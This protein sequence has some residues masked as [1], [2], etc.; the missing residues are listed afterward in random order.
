MSSIELPAHKGGLF[1]SH[2]EHRNYYEPLTSWLKSRGPFDWESGAHRQRAID[3]D[4]CWVLQWYPNTPI[5][6]LLVAA[7][8]LDECLAFAASPGR[9][10][11]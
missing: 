9:R 6:F 1:L 10:E 8:T 5:G 11:G 2:N 4:E 7:P 3:T